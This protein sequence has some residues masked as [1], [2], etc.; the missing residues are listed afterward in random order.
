MKKF[1]IISFNLIYSMSLSDLLSHKTIFQQDKAVS[2]TS[3]LIR[4]TIGLAFFLHGAQK[5]F[6]WF[7][8]SGL[9]KWSEYLGT[10]NY[11]KLTAYFSAYA[12]MIAGILLIAGVC[13]KLSAGAML[14]FMLFAV[15]IAH[16]E[17]GYFS[18][19]GGYEYQLL[20]IV[21]C[22]VLIILGG[23]EYSLDK[24]IFPTISTFTK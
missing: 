11:S 18:N 19:K 6:G 10:Q 15:W 13:T 20:L 8:G 7:G 23:G 24:Y 21:A 17:K 1:I 2:V 9:E 16:L 22:V 12:E 5:V 14:I 3:L 4:L